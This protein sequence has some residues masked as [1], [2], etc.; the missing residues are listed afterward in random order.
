MESSRAEKE[1]IQDHLKA[2]DGPGAEVGWNNVE[3]Y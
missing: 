3:G 1:K 2:Y